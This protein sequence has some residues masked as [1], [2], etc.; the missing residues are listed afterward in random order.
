MLRSA[1][2]YPTSLRLA[3]TLLGESVLTYRLTLWGI[4]MH[5]L[6]SSAD[7]TWYLVDI[8]IRSFGQL[9]IAP[10]S[11]MGEEDL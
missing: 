4:E 3:V 10:V 8:A 1:G 5:W 7:H 6:C 9:N 2:G 11:D